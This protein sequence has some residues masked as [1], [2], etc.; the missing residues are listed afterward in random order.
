[1][2]DGTTS[3]QS[4][5]TAVHKRGTIMLVSGE[6]DKALAAFDI[7]AGFQ[8]MGMQMSMWFVFY[9]ANCLLKPRSLLSPDKWFRGLRGGPGRRPETDVALQRVVRGLVPAG[10]G[11]LP[12]SQCNFAG[13][14]PLIIR[15]IFRRKGIAHLE[16][17]IHAA[18]DLGVR[19]TICQ[20]CVDAM[21]IS[22]PDDLIVPVNVDGV[23]AYYLESAAAD[24][25]CLL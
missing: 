1:M 3:P 10:A 14:G 18:H 21:A 13:I 12:L 20:T 5:A 8:A 6:L 17:L 23:S 9:G 15:H 24:Y 16:D 7:A 25:N 22:V 4:D 11:H 19:F 2:S